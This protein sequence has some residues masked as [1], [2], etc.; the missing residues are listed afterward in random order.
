MQKK[1]IDTEAQRIV[2]DV[3]I[4]GFHYAAASLIEKIKE[5]EKCGDEEST[6]ESIAVCK[7][8]ID[9]LAKIEVLYMLPL[10]EQY[11]SF[12][13][14]A[15]ISSSNNLLEIYDRRN[16]ALASALLQGL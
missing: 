16:H 13:N 15:K 1:L 10:R 7:L 2:I 3:V 6:Q 8:R 5:L 9:T 12:E 4:D 14:P 11:E